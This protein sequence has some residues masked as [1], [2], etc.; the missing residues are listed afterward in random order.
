MV[1]EARRAKHP[2]LTDRRQVVAR[3][4]DRRSGAS[5]ID[6]ST[7]RKSKPRTTFATYNQPLTRISI[8]R[9]GWTQNRVQTVDH[10]LRLPLDRRKD[11]LR[12]RTM[13]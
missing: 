10:G 5:L 4:L 12:S 13:D 2:P 8:V 1:V 6:L 3:E 7:G 11:F 9:S